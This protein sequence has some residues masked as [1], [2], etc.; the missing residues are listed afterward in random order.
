MAEHHEASRHDR[1]KE[2][3]ESSAVSIDDQPRRWGIIAG[4]F[5][6]FATFFLPQYALVPF[7]GFFSSLPI[8]RNAKLFMLQGISE[9]ATVVLLWLV[10]KNIYRT[11]L[12]SIGLGKFGPGLLGWSVL[13]FP[14]YIIVSTFFS[15]LAAQLFGVNLLQQQ[16]IGYS[17]PNG[18]ELTLTFLALVLLAPFVEETLFR[19]FLFKAFRR[20]FGFWGGAVGVSLLF[21]VAHGQANVGIDVFVLSMFLCYLREKTNSLWPSIALHALKNLVAFIILF[22]IKAN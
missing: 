4:T 9:L 13:A 1:D 3:R 2:T 14:V 19:G 11:D 20:T 16:N 18:F 8:D 15:N 7:L 5:W 22:I 10:M 12:K 6:G 21:A 17:N